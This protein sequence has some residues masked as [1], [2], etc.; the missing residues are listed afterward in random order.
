MVLPGSLL[1]SLD[2][3]ARVRL[4]QD[5]TFL[6]MAHQPTP[7]GALPTESPQFP[8]SWELSTDLIFPNLSFSYSPAHSK[9]SLPSF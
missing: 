2:Q 7:P 9:L 1:A 5:F 6:E 8:V 4:P 3:A